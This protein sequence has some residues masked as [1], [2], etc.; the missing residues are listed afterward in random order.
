MTALAR[1]ADSIR[2]ASTQTERTSTLSQSER[3]QPVSNELPNLHA[4]SPNSGFA[5]EIRSALEHDTPDI[6]AS[7]SPMHGLAL[8]AP[9][10]GASALR[11]AESAPAVYQT[12]APMGSSAWLG[13]MASVATLSVRDRVQQAEIRIDPAELGP[14][15][16]RLSLD[17]DSTILSFAVT[18]PDTRMALE[19]NLPRLKEAFEAAGLQLAD[20]SVSDGRAQAQTSGNHSGDL[21][22]QA[23]FDSRQP[24]GATV[25]I[26]A[27][28]A[29]LRLR[30]AIDTFA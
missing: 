16:L 13:E 7:A 6:A 15:T 28:A 24:T 5:G 12:H 8:H 3:A 14:I 30:G 1:L 2:E 17:G 26:E 25:Q 29:P 20:A 21:R 18:H 4:A 22:R 11:A 27:L 23:T 19:A 9:L 10:P